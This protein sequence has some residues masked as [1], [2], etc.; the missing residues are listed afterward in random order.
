MRCCDPADVL[1]VQGSLCCQGAVNVPCINQ[2]R[3]M[4][5]EYVIGRERETLLSEEDFERTILI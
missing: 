3:G 2:L 5:H 4:R 1:L